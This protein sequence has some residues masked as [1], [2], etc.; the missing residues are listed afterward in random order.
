MHIGSYEIHT[1]ETGEFALDGGA[2]FGVVPKTLWSRRIPV[3]DKN[4]IDMRLRC[5]LLIGDGKNI[6]IDCGMGTKWDEKMCDIYRLDYSRY[7]LDKAL[8]A[9][10]LTP[11][12]ITDVILTHLHFD[13][14]GGSTYKEA[15]GKLVPTFPNATYYIGRENFD[16]AK[17][18][19]EKDR[20]SYIKE[21]WEPLMAAGVLKIVEGKKEILP[22]IQ[23]RLF[24]GHTQGIQLPLIDDGKT[25]LFFC[26]D[27]IP[28]SVH[29]GIPWVMAYDILPMTT[30]KEK[31][32][33]LVQAAQENWILIFEHCPHVG[34][35][36]IKATE[37]GFEISEQVD[38]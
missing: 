15:G 24:Y 26:G 17:A 12:K 3:D 31:K 30:M 6:L 29:L 10:N 32:E 9:H 19:T 13:H 14:A 23:M 4:R 5:L 38:L 25:K 33:I 35:A 21:D 34:A 8:A 36:R 16:W 28:T 20:A 2:M 7:T 37:K 18:P 27:V 1:I 22:G 11:D